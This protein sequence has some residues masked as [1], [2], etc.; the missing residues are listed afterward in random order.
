M[1][2]KF[3]RLYYTLK[4]LQFKQLKYQVLY[5]LNKAKPLGSYDGLINPEKVQRLGF[6][7][8]PPVYRHILNDKHFSFLN[9]EVDYQNDIDWNDQRHGKLWNY[10]LQYVNYLFQEDIDNDVKSQ[11]LHSLYDSL[12]SQKLELEPYPVSLRTINC[13]RWCSLQGINDAF[14]LKAVHAELD[15]LSQRPEYHILG[16]HLLENAFALM[17]GGAFFAEP[18]WLAQGQELLEKE[19]EEQILADGAHF[20]LSPMYHQIIFFR[21]LELI[22]WYS[23]WQGQSVDF[24]ALLRKKASAMKSWLQHIAFQNGDIPH[25][26]DSADGVAYSTAWLNSYADQLS[27]T[28]VDLRLDASGYRS[29]EKGEYECKVDFAQVGPSYQPGHAHADALSF[30]LNH[31]QQPFFVER[32]TS[33]YQIG[34]IRHVERSTAA[35]NTVVVNH[36]NQSNI[37]GGFRV[38]ERAEVKITADSEYEIA[39]EHHGYRKYGVTHHRSMRFSDTSIVIIDD[40]KGN[41]S[42]L[43]EFHLHLYPGLNFTI[44]EK[45]VRIENK[46]TLNFDQPIQIVT[47][48]YQMAQGFNHYRNAKKIVVTFAQTLTT[49][50]RFDPF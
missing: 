43:K 33:T 30:I 22:D 50:I 1:I 27:I 6:K 32:G 31:Q 36:S 13:I 8:Q 23:A 29:I 39:A 26:S 42:A 41:A 48:D 5:R 14:I 35:H 17:M 47:E 2:S 11:L 3:K 44:N 46:A 28:N 15:F 10:N 16:N 21:L 7:E 38:A 12:Y 24:L 19:L 45:E 34:K 18:T 40:V 9:L 20:E 37:W 49:T 25:F 4:P